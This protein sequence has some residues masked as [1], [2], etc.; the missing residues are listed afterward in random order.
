MGG[1]SVLIWVHFFATDFRGVDG[2]IGTHGSLTRAELQEIATGG[3][4]GVHP[5]S[6]VSDTEAWC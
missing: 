2:Q 1:E 6:G 4:K 5:I 3:P